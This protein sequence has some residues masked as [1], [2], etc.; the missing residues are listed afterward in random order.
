GR[1]RLRGRPRL[2]VDTES[3]RSGEG[4]GSPGRPTTGSGR[5]PGGGRAGRHVLYARCAGEHDWR[6]CGRERR[7]LFTDLAAIGQVDRSVAPRPLFGLGL[8]CFDWLVV[9]IVTA[10]GARIR[11]D[12]QLLVLGVF[13]L[14][15]RRFEFAQQ[16]RSTLDGDAAGLLDPLPYGVA[17]F[18]VNHFPGGAGTGGLSGRADGAGA[19]SRP[20]R[21]GLRS[22]ASGRANSGLGVAWVAHGLAYNG[23]STPTVL[24][25][26]VSVQRVT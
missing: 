17:A 22:G 1:L 12:P 18:I 7:L 3:G 6:G 21:G 2:G 15:V 11:H 16:P 26:C 19:G 4:Q 23:A 13:H 14:E 10:T 20:R 25:L 8:R 9:R 24:A 5:N